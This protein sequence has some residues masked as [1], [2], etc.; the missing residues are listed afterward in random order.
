MIGLSKN[1]ALE[2][3]P[4]IDYVY[5]PSNNYDTSL[6]KLTAALRLAPSAEFAAH[7]RFRMFATYAAWGNG[8]V[9]QSIGGTAFNNKN[10]G[11]NAGLQCEHW[12]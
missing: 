1:L 3:E 11:L 6:F 7:P 12:W 9:N 5:D 10:Y 2:L 4:G 8:F